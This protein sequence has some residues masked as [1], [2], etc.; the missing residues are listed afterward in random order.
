MMLRTQANSVRL[1]LSAWKETERSLKTWTLSKELQTEAEVR[2]KACVG[3]AEFVESR[4]ATIFSSTGSLKAA[5]WLKLTKLGY[6]I[7]CVHLHTHA[8]IRK[9]STYT[10]ICTYKH[11]HMY[12]CITGL[13]S[14]YMYIIIIEGLHNRTE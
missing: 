3:V 7:I 4:G 14:D 10:C 13:A 5:D 6:V 2:A 8:R 11:V 9:I 12:T 1:K